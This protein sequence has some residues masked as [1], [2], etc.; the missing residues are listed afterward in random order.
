[1][2]VGGE[3]RGG[4]LLAP[5]GLGEEVEDDLELLVGIAG[6]QLVQRPHP[7][8]EQRGDGGVDTLAVDLD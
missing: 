1:M 4:L 8:G 3:P 2:L 6:V 7:V 5:G